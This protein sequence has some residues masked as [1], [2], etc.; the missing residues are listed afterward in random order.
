MIIDDYI[1]KIEKANLEE[2]ID[3]KFYSLHATGWSKASCSE[4]AEART[5]SLLKT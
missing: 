5:S 2:T 3:E 4:K 1:K